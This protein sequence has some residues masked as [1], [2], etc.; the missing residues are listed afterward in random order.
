[1]SERGEGAQVDHG[2]VAFGKGGGAAR[3]RDILQEM[4][5]YQ[6]G[7]IS[8]SSPPADPRKDR[9]MG[10]SRRSLIAGIAASPAFVPT[11][12]ARET[13]SFEAIRAAARGQTVYWNAWGGDDPTN[14]FIAWAGEETQRRYGVSIRH[15]RLRDTAEAVARVIAERQAGRSAGGAV[16]L[17]WINGP[18]FLSMKTQGLLFGPF[19]EA[20]PNWPLVDIAGKPSNVV[21]FTVSVDGLAA[22]WRLAQVVF[23]HDSART[24]AATLPASMA[25]ML[26]WAQR[27]PGRLTHPTARNF[28]GATFLKQALVELAGEADAL[29]REPDDATFERSAVALWRWYDALRPLLWRQ[30]RDFPESG[31][32]MLQMLADG[33]TDLVISFNPAD[34]AASIASGLLP[35]S[36]RVHVLAGGT[37][38][39]TSFVAIPFNAAHKEGAM[40]VANFLL[41][42]ATQARAQDPRHLGSF[43]VL[44]VDRLPEAAQAPFRALASTPALPTN[45]Q[46]GRPLP[47]PHPGWMTRLVSAWERRVT[48]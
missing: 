24:P 11:S 46:L 4:V 47:E 48:G 45:A 39:N 32:A 42:P 29:A 28:L 13:R 40:V 9:A 3:R 17:I 43:S 7:G 15:V 38:G 44:A 35:A 18:N 8:V 6:E 12:R 30:G 2:V 14:A 37:L 25:A 10:P 1:M 34:A 21:D 16:D 26:P 19:V 41:E 23:V 31:P 5:T 33:E 22:P 20:L 27:H 36:A